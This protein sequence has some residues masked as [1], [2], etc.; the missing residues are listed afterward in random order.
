MTRP[1][2][3]ATLPSIFVTSCLSVSICL[4]ARKEFDSLNLLIGGTRASYDIKVIII[5]VFLIFLILYELA[6]I[7]H[8]SRRLFIYFL[9]SSNRI[10]HDGS[11]ITR[12]LD[13]PTYLPFNIYKYVYV[14]LAAL[15]SD[16]TNIFLS[17]FDVN[18]QYFYLTLI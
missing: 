12:N 5:Y 6:K 13:L 16:L 17:I 7:P 15:W 1:C 8:S 18:F 2:Q 10:W 11:L 4:L 14:T 3:L 9:I